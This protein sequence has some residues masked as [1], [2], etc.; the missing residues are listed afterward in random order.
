[1]ADAGNPREEMLEQAGQLV[2]SGRAVALVASDHE[3]LSAILGE[4]AMSLIEFGGE[5]TR[6]DAMVSHERSDISRALA[7][8][9]RV[10]ESELVDVLRLRG[11]TSN[12]LLLLVDNAECLSTG[13]MRRLAELM[14]LTGG[15]L[16]L[17]MAGEMELED[18]LDEG[19]LPVDL[20]FDADE[21]G[22]PPLLEDEQEGEALVLPWKH[23]SAVMGLLLLIWLLWPREETP[24]PQVQTLVL[25][26]PVVLPEVVAEP[27]GEAE[28]EM[29]DRPP[30]PAVPAMDEPPSAEVAEPSPEPAPTEA[31]EIAK[32]PAPPPPEPQAQTEDVSE[33]PLTGLAAEL[34]YRQEDWLLA[35]NAQHWVLQVALGSSEDAAR[36]VLDRLGKR[37]GAYYRTRRSGEEV[38]IVLAGTWA[39]RDQALQARASLPPE[40]RDRG[41]FPRQVAAIQSEILAHLR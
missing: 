10:P 41:P 38:Y 21:V 19:A 13:A 26:E 1:M 14:A 2:M 35:A 17:A 36:R 37:R 20:V 8:T 24:E 11:D 28:L 16:G 4:L 12:P 29:I 22:V 25:P 27:D 31:E 23:I 18:A 34:G 30:A 32:V 3:A 5:I 15:G 7:D 6:L 9:L 33:P 40:L 39:D